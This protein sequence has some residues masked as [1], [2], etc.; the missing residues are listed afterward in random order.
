MTNVSAATK[1]KSYTAR[2]AVAGQRK[3]RT[4]VTRAL[5]D[6]FRTDLKQA[7]NAGEAFDV[8]TGLPE[9]MAPK[10]SGMSWLELVQKYVEM[11]WPEAA[12]NSRRGMIESLVAV[13]VV[14]VSEAAPHPRTRP[15]SARRCVSFWCRVRP[16]PPTQIM[17]THSAGCGTTPFRPPRSQTSRR[18][19]RRSTRWPSSSTGPRRRRRLGGESEPSSTTSS[20]T[21]SNSGSSTTTRS[22]GFACGLVDGPCRKPSIVRWSPTSARSA[23]S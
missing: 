17:P 23:S 13:T 7:V 12:A 14:L 6:N 2:W 9:S 21:E 1:K 18:S 5:A 15:L 4:F 19:A 11:K 22:T 8:E 3:S 16:I 20:S 10:E